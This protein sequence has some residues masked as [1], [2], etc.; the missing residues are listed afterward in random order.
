VA[1]GDLHFDIEPQVKVPKKPVLRYV[2]VELLD[3]ATIFRVFFDVFL[4]LSMAA[5]GAALSS[6]NAI[7]TMHKAFLAV[8]GL[9][10]AVFL[11]LDI[12]WMWRA[13]NED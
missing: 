11:S 9:A 7:G 13:R 4:A 10:A 2:R 5:L 8:T 12:T 3:T 6:P 1:D